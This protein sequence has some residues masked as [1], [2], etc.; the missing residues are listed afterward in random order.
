VF[1]CQRARPSL[2]TNQRT[3]QWPAIVV[4]RRRTDEALSDV[5]ELGRGQGHVTHL[6]FCLNHIFVIGEARHFK[7]RGVIDTEKYE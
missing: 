5:T 6:Q 3:S 2:A 7:F 4:N 1:N